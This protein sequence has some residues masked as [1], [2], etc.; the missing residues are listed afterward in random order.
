M[1]F[2]A[3]CFLSSVQ[4]QSS[5]KTYNLLFLPSNRNYNGTVTFVYSVTDSNLPGSNVTA[6]VTLT[7][8]PAVLPPVAL[9]NTYTGT[10]GSP[11]SP[12]SGSLLVDDDS[13]PYNARLD[14][15]AFGT[16]SVGTVTFQ[17]NGTFVF[18]PPS[19][20]WFGTAVFPYTITDSSTG[21]NATAY[22]HVTV[23]PPVPVAVDDAYSCP[24][25]APCSPPGGA[26]GILS[27]DTSPSGGT[28]TVTGVVTPPNVGTVT[29]DANGTF[30]YTPPQ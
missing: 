1:C 28:L 13:S 10:F 17:P 8:L 7:I 2:F 22:A 25:N 3:C 15:V 16:P 5:H 20:T 6:T 30:V 14:I 19:L 18:T 21:L 29:V 23:A 26:P 27:N 12:P 4:T 11:Y 9:N 24:Y